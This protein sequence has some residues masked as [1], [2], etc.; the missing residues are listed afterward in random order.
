MVIALLGAGAQVG[1]LLPYSRGQESEADRLGLDYM[2]RAGF[3]PRASVRLW[4]NMAEQGGAQPPEFLS[5][6]PSHGSRIEE[7]QNHMP[8]AIGLYEQARA[9]GRKPGC[10][11]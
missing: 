5:T 1:I 4:Q 8:G 3:N 10:A 7:L 9:R 2:A 11:P 6:H